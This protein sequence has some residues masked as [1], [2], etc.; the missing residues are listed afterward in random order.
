MTARTSFV[1]EGMLS[2]VVIGTEDEAIQ[3]M[4][5]DPVDHQTI[6][7][8]VSIVQIG[9]QEKVSVNSAS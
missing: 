2:T 8:N 4:P 5:Y 1:L 6:E 7:S 3:S 9:G